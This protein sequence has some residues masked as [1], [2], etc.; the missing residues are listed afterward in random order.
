MAHDVKL[1]RHT[2]VGKPL[3]RRVAHIAKATIIYASQQVGVAGQHQIFAL[4]VEVER[5]VNVG[6]GYATLLIVSLLSPFS[7]TNKPISSEYSFV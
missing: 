4:L 3:R 1:D 6:T 5:Q 2:R 7:K